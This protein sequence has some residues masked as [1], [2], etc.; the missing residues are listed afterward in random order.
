[1]LI[2]LIDKPNTSHPFWVERLGG[3]YVLSDLTA[4]NLLHMIPEFENSNGE[5]QR[6]MLYSHLF[7]LDIR[8]VKTDTTW[9]VLKLLPVRRYPEPDFRHRRGSD[10]ALL[11]RGTTDFGSNPSS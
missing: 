3:K 7:Q 6:C 1:V 5:S 8:R 11:A 10:S 2:D 9:E 4:Y